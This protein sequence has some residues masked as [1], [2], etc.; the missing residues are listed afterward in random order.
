MQ[1][2]IYYEAQDK[3]IYTVRQVLNREQGRGCS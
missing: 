2:R 3:P 1:M